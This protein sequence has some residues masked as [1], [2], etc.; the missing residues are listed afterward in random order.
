MLNSSNTDEFLY[1]QCSSILLLL[2]DT[3]TRNISFV[4]AECANNSKEIVVESNADPEKLASDLLK[5]V[6]SPNEFRYNNLSI[7]TKLNI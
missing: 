1:I 5:N 7:P 4:T 6:N 3:K 2:K